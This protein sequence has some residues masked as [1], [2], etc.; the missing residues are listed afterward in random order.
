MK[1]FKNLFLLGMLVLVPAFLWAG[2]KV[3]PKSDYLKGLDFYSKGQYEAALLRFQWAIDE[4]WNFWQ[5]YQMVGYCY[6]ELRDKEGALNAFA[7]SLK[8]HPNNPKLAKIY[9][10]LKSGNLDIPMRPVEAAQPIG[11][12][13]YIYTYYSYHR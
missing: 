13:V 12:P 1:V 3:T 6:F 10:D 7:E 5:S 4:D 9:N 8:I 2:S 11:T